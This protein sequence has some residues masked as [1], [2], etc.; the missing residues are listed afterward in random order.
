MQSI[1]DHRF[2][3]RKYDAAQVLEA[4]GVTVRD[5]VDLQKLIDHLLAVVN[6]TVP[7]AQISLWLRES[8]RGKKI[9]RGT[10]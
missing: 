5:E 3:R 4:F 8:E 6:E 10:E 1:I 7:P 9:E 2:Y